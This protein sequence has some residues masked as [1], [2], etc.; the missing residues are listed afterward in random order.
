M[1]AQQEQTLLDTAREKGEVLGR[2]P[3]TDP[4]AGDRVCVNSNEH[5]ILEVV[6]VDEHS[7]CWTRSNNN[8]SARKLVSTRD[9]WARGQNSEYD[10]VAEFTFAKGSAP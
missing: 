1:S 7:V 10:R 9:A 3:H 4:R 5:H 8:W 2:N 6:S